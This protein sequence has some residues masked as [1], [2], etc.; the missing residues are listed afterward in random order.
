MYVVTVDHVMSE[1]QPQSSWKPVS[2]E[3]FADWFDSDGRLVREVTMRQRDKECLRLHVRVCL[4]DDFL[5]VCSC[6]TKI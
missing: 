1:T 3:E 5:P 2:A 6:P 4:L